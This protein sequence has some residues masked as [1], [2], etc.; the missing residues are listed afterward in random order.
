MSSLVITQAVIHDFLTAYFNPFIG[1][2]FV[3]SGEDPVVSYVDFKETPWQ[4]ITL[5]DT[6][7]YHLFAT[8]SLLKPPT[9]SPHSLPAHALISHGVFPSFLLLGSGVLFN[10]FLII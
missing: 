5:F 1:S 10:L 3:E 4:K 6:Q 2:F 9:E 7:M 8:F